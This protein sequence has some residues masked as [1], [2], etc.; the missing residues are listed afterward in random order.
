MSLLTQ[1]DKRCSD[2]IFY[3]DDGCQANDIYD[4]VEYMEEKNGIRKGQ[5]MIDWMK[6]SKEREERNP[7]QSNFVK[8]SKNFIIIIILLVTSSCEDLFQG[9]TEPKLFLEMSMDYPYDEKS[10][11]YIVDY[12]LENSHWYVRVSIKSNPRNRV[13]FG[14]PVEFGVYYQGRW[15]Y[16][17]IIQ[18]SVYVKDDSTSQQLVY[19]NKSM[20][21]EML[22]IFAVVS[23]V[24]GTHEIK[25][26][27]FIDLQ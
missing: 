12:P 13:F 18:H 9:S 4:C 1:K 27:L 16:E 3:D 5:W 24:D 7:Y 23:D 14:S 17:P 25:D 8:W 26:S 21:G 19:L 15:I 2:C 6:K 11:A 22:P 10:R 20:I